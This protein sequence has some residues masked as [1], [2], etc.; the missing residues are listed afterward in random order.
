MGSQRRHPLRD[1]LDLQDRMNRVFEESLREGESIRL[2]GQWNPQVDMIEDD[3]ALYIL[4][5]LPGVKREDIILDFSEGMITI[6]G[7]KPFTRGNQSENYYMVER[8]YGAFRRTF[9]IPHAIDGNAIQAKL[10][11]G[12]LEIRMPKLNNFRTRRI[13]ITEK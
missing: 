1:I 12:I 7:K 8:Q 10:E 9:S 11:G 5:E 4:A 2:P 3:E 13:S 6:S